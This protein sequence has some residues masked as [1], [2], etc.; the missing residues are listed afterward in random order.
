MTDSQPNPSPSDVLGQTAPIN[1]AWPVQLVEPYRQQLVARID[2]VHRRFMEATEQDE[3][4]DDGAQPELERLHATI[5][6]VGDK[7]TLVE[8]LTRRAAQAELDLAQARHDLTMQERW[9]K[10]GQLR[11]EA[12]CK[13]A[14]VAQ[15]D[16][17]TESGAYTAGND[18]QLEIIELDLQDAAAELGHERVALEYA[19]QRVDLT[20]RMHR[21][22]N[23][24]L[25][26]AKRAE[27]RAKK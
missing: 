10:R 23:T 5:P 8:W 7:P 18:T 11:Y 17:L 22:I 25:R 26:A 12:R 15:I 1:P 14:R 20:K 2:E 4:V 27:E 24:A 3:A 21:E 13:E 9:V 6:D 19:R 16:H